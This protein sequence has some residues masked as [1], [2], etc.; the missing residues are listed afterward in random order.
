MSIIYSSHDI[1]IAVPSS[2]E[3]VQD[4][5]AW[6]AS[7]NDSGW[8]VLTDFRNWTNWIPGVHRVKQANSEPPAR[9][10]KLRVD[11]GRKTVSCSIDH[12]DPPRCLQISINH[13]SGEMA[14]G[15][16]I[17]TYPKKAE[18][19]ISLELEQ[20]LIGVSRIAAFFFR[21]RQQR[22]GRQ[23]LAKLVDRTRSAKDLS[24]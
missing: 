18:M 21:W 6:L 24:G 14:Y 17:E 2:I 8:R 5:H 3:K 12:W 1:R 20:S 11:G 23:M 19:R 13:A 4:A 22:L 15:F 16:L 10:T 9:G 7:M